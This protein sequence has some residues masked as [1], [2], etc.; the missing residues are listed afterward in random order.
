MN[1]SLHHDLSIDRNMSWVPD[2]GYVTYLTLNAPGASVNYDL[3]VGSGNV[4]Q[5]ASFGTSVADLIATPVV[6]VPP[7][8]FDLLFPALLIAGTLI[9]V[10]PFSVWQLRPR[11]FRG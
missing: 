2:H 10:V 7:D 3:S 5:L 1:A 11:R 8:P 4:I 9:I 6:P